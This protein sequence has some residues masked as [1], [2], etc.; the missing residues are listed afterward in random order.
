M[1]TLTKQIID[2]IEYE[3]SN[4]YFPIKIADFTFKEIGGTF[5]NYLAWSAKN[6]M[7][8]VPAEDLSLRYYACGHVAVS[9]SSEIMVLNEHSKEKWFL[10][11]I[12]LKGCDIDRDVEIVVRGTSND[13]SRDKKC[14][15]PQEFTNAW[16]H[17]S[18]YVFLCQT[19]C[20]LI[21][22]AVFEDVKA[23]VSAAASDLV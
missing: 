16:P 4:Q 15:L 21:Q 3:S 19:L 1:N 7:P 18:D 10:S 20:L 12:V 13:F 17:L 8:S 2:S 14:F 5:E 9:T 23:N 11:D 22:D 6:L